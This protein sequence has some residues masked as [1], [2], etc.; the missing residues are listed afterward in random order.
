MQRRAGILAARAHASQGL[1]TTSLWHPCQRCTGEERRSAY[2]RVFQE[3]CCIHLVSSYLPRFRDMV[4]NANENGAS[5]AC[6]TRKRRGS[7]PEPLPQEKSDGWSRRKPRL[8]QQTED[9][10]SSLRRSSS[11]SGEEREDAP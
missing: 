10:M 4:F 9:F 5:V 2:L 11:Q 8:A 6:L 3:S 7:S 1:D